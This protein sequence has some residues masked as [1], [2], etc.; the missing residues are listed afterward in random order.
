M[1]ES[2]FV[3]PIIDEGKF[4]PYEIKRHKDGTSLRTSLMFWGYKINLI[5]LIDKES[6]LQN[7]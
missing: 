6:Y 5:N 1:N 2:P 4:R 7:F 3:F